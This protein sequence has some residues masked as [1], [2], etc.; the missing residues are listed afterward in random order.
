MKKTLLLSAIRGS[1]DEQMLLYEQNGDV[2]DETIVEMELT[3]H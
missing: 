3:V 1:P 2:V